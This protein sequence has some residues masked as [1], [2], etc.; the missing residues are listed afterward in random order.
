MRLRILLASFLLGAILSPGTKAQATI[1]IISGGAGFLSSTTSG[2]TT[3]EPTIAPVLTVP[4]G[5]RWLI[6]SRAYFVEDIHPTNGNGPYEGQFFNTLE[7][8]QVDFLATRWLTITAGRYLTPFN[9]Y[10]ERLAPIWI[11]KFQDAPIIYPI[12]TTQGYSDGGMLRGSLISNDDYQITYV[13]YFS[14][15]STINKLNSQRSAGGRTSIFFPRQRLEIGASYARLLQNEEMNFEGVFFSWLPNPVPLD[16]KAEYAHSP[17]GQGYWLQGTYRLAKTNGMPRGWGRIEALGR[18][19]QFQRLQ[20]GSGDGLPGVNTQRVDAGA[21]YHFP[22]EV[23]F[24]A[25]WGR[26]FTTTSGRNLW[27]FQLTYRFLFPL[28]P[29]GSQ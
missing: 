21:Q 3:I 20:A 15:L 13:A 17:R 2:E 28:W 18:V 16:I 10:N 11:E 29:G 8:G 9:M 23:R 22:H 1:P 26:Q 27:E 4:I 25:T 5:S 24:T 6:E 14:T 12:G 19:Q 7:Y